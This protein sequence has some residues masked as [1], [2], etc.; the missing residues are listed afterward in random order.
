MVTPTGEYLQKRPPTFTPPLRHVDR[1]AKRFNLSP[2]SLSEGFVTLVLPTNPFFIPF[3]VFFLIPRP[4]RMPARLAKSA[5]QDTCGSAYNEIACV[6]SRVLQA[7][8]RTG[9]LKR[10]DI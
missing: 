3:C 8:T 7:T 2:T 10:K 5:L 4:D 6:D 1:P 9:T